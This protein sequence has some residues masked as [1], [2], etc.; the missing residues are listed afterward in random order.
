MPLVLP[1]G[2]LKQKAETLRAVWVVEG[3]SDLKMNEWMNKQAESW[4]CITRKMRRQL[5]ATHSAWH[6]EWYMMVENP[7]CLYMYVCMYVHGCL[8]GSLID[9]DCRCQYEGHTDKLPRT[10]RE[11]GAAAWA[12]FLNRGTGPAKH[13][14]GAY[15]F[16]RVPLSSPTI[17]ILRKSITE[18]NLRTNTSTIYIISKGNISSKVHMRFTKRPKPKVMLLKRENNR[19]WTFMG[20]CLPNPSFSPPWAFC[21]QSHWPPT[22]VSQ[23]R[24][25]RDWDSLC[26]NIRPVLSQNLRRMK[27]MGCF[28]LMT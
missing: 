28:Y 19:W 27:S 11:E 23:Q 26:G 14:S 16:E 2:S 15:Y 20:T 8:T 18:A 24:Q 1:L 13:D 21:W 7:L 17:C 12:S 22:H 9:S 6:P 3:D 4:L 25:V 5:W 10:R